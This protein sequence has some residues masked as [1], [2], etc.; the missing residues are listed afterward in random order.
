MGLFNS[1]PKKQ[2]NSTE[3]IVIAKDLLDKARERLVWA[4]ELATEE[5]IRAEEVAAQW[6]SAAQAA[7]VRKTETTNLLNQLD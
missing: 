4:E 1:K 3:Q 5:Q 2:D 7:A 6:M